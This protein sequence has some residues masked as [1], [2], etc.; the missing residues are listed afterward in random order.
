[1]LCMLLSLVSCKDDKEPEVPPTVEDIVAE[2]SA[3]NLKP[4][5]EG[6]DVD[7]ANVKIE[8]AKSDA[9]DKVTIILRNVV[10]GTPEFKIPDA[11]FAATTRSEYISTLKG[12]VSDD[13]AGYNVKVD[14]TVDNKVLTVKIVLTEIEGK[15]VNTSSLYNSVYKGKMDINVANIPEPISMEQRV[16]I[17]KART[18]NMAKR[19]TSMVK[20]TIQNFA[21][22]GMELGDITLDTI[23]VQKRGEVLAFKA[24]SRKI[25]LAIIGEVDATLQGTIVDEKMSLSLDIDA[26]GLK[27]NVIFEG[28]PTD[29]KKVAKITKMTIEGDAVVGQLLSGTK[30]TIKVWE[31]TPDAQLLLTPVYELS[32]KATI[33]SVTIHIDGK[34][35]DVKLTADQISGKQPIDLSQLKSSKDYVKYWL[36]AEDPNVKNNFLI[37]V[38]RIPIISTDYTF[39]KWIPNGQQAPFDYSEPEGWATSNGAAT[40]LKA[41]P[42]GEGDFLYAHNLP[43]P[44]SPVERS[45]AKIITVDTKG[46]DL[47]IAVVPAITSGTLFLGT[48]SIALDN[49]LKS[50]KFGVPYNKKP[51]SFKGEYTY[52][53]G[54]IYYKTVVKTVDGKKEVSKEELAETDKCSINAILYEVVDYSET[55]DGTNI[56]SSDKLVAVAL[57]SEGAQQSGS[58]D[59]SFNYVKGYDASKKYKLAIVCSSSAKGDSFEGA[60]GSELIV[61]KLLVSNE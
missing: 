4:T 46:A 12:E 17:A 44:V 27:V 35:P 58:F 10:P 49:T 41:M 61:K 59:I 38:E 7:A 6:V 32:E 37:Y 52:T 25:K 24:E 21:F 2:Y 54:A 11:E 28:Q 5:I 33:D 15:N 43:F 57:V 48:F 22:Q 39:N 60:P 29:E 30:Y 20:L 47:G 55:L 31:D 16:Y 50:T 13:L 1:M 3:E 34:K 56:N 8:L 51:K 26:S 53:P 42:Y 14:G 36:A 45:G 9:S 40:M 23:L 19:D 18:T